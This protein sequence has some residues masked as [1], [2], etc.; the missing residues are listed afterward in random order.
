[1]IAKSIACLP[2]REKNESRYIFDTS[3][4]LHFC[5][6]ILTQAFGIS[7]GYDCKPRGFLAIAKE[8]LDAKAFW[9][10]QLK[11]I[12]SYVEDQIT[13]NK[14]YLMNKN[15]ELIER[16]IEDEE[17]RVLG[18][19]P[20]SDPALEKALRET[21]T[22]LDDTNNNLLSQTIEWGRKCTLYANN[23]LNRINRDVASAQSA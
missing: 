21:D 22:L 17:M 10:T 19:A 3:R 16:R 23:K 13:A 14:L 2:D 15:H 8:K 9:T 18:I 5:G 4:R 7:W 11:E 6:I 1:M 20:Y 12:Q